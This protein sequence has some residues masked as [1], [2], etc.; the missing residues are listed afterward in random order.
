MIVVRSKNL[1]RIETL[2][3]FFPKKEWSLHDPTGILHTEI[4]QRVASLQTSYQQVYLHGM[5]QFYQQV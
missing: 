5:L 3:P 4:L 1:S 2:L